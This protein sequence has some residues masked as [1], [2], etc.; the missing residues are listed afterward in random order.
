[1]RH[2]NLK[3][4]IAKTLNKAIKKLYPK[5]KVKVTHEDIKK[6]K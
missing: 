3:K 5:S 1:M 4:Q 6:I 2:K